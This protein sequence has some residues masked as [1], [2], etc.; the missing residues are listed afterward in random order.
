M[1]HLTRE[2]KLSV[3]LDFM[4]K[5]GSKIRVAATHFRAPVPS[6]QVINPRF[7]ERLDHSE[8]EV[9]SLL[10]NWSG[11][12]EVHIKK[13]FSGWSQINCILVLA[14]G[15]GWQRRFLKELFQPWLAMVIEKRA[16]E[17]HIGCGAARWPGLDT[18]CVS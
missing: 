7:R 13:H 9:S 14:V 5:A 2:E 18:S 10:A 6:S 3:Y 12:Q 1:C 17:P 4:G 8:D 11:V 16:L 15:R